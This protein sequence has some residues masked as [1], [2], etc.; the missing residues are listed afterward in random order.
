MCYGQNTYSTVQAYQTL[1]LQHKHHSDSDI[2]LLLA[3][4]NMDFIVHT[5]QCALLLF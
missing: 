3:S 1:I 5:I 4:L 2:F